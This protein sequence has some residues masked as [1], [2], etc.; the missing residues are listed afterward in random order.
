MDFQEGQRVKQKQKATGSKRVIYVRTVLLMVFCGLFMFTPLIMRLW[1]LSIENHEKYSQ[2]AVSQQTRDVVVSADRGEILDTNGNVLAISAT[3]YQL[4]LSPLDVQ[5]SVSQSVYTEDEVLDEVAY[6]AAIDSRKRVLIDG[7]SAITGV[8]EEVLENRMERTYSQ[9]EIIKTDIE[10]T[11]ADE[12]R[13]FLLENNCGYDLYLTPDSKRYYPHAT[14]A[15][16][17]VGFVNSAGGAYGIEAVYEDDLSGEAGRV[18]SSKTGTGVAMYDSYATY[19]DA[20]NGYDVTLTI[21]ANIQYYAEKALA[22]GIEAYDVLRG[23][24]CI[25]MN[26]KTGDILAMASSPDYDLNNYTTLSSE[27]LEAELETKTLA[28]LESYLQDPDHSGDTLETLEG[29]AAYDAKREVLSYQWRSQA[30]NDTYEPGSTFKALLLAAALEEGVIDVDDHYY[31]P[32]YYVVNGTRIGCS[33]TTGHGDQTLAEAVQ[34]SCNPAFMMI[35]QALG[36]EK[37]YD[38]FEAFGLTQSTGIELVGEGTSLM[39]TREYL[40]SLEGYLSLATASFGQRF[41]VTPLQMINGFAATI[42]G[43]YLMVPHVVQSVMD[44]NGTAVSVTQTETVRQVVSEETSQLCREILE[45]VVSEGSGSKAYVSGYQIGGKTGTSET[46]VDGEVVVSFMGF[47]PAD[48]PEILVLLGYNTP[49]RVAEGNDYSTTGVYISGGNMA[50]PMAG[51]LIGNILDYLGVDKSYTPEEAARADV[52]MPAVVGAT[53]SEASTSL[54]RVD[55]QYRTVGEGE[56]VT[57][58]VPASGTSIP[59]GSTVILYLGD[60]LPPETVEVPDL[61][62]LD[63]DDTKDTLEAAGLFMRVVGSNLSYGS[64]TVAA[65]QSVTAG[66]TVAMGTVIDVSF[67]SSEMQDGYLFQ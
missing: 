16:H 67:L 2:A 59:G 61:L 62:D 32:G 49:N 9:Y 51:Q 1:E 43:G 20:V 13:A 10:Q 60:Q 15:S 14:L 44:Q 5:A 39:H 3:V 45:S 54:A 22:E 33:K 26:P 47:A 17:L 55:L 63:Y 64:S 52:K 56:T 38:Y 53:V 34:N 6:Q 18:V 21:D 30:I 57:A 66:E 50:A 12:I 48:D 25:V 46:T 19:V 41:T 35:G 4:V 36:A 23:G 7:I 42:N 27:E 11:E 65:T 28:Y 8:S 40:T 24:F 31:C 29:L 37:F 58:Q